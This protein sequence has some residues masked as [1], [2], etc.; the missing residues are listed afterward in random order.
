ML[1]PVLVVLA[2]VAITIFIISPFPVS[3][4]YTSYVAS[5]AS[6]RSGVP[7]EWQSSQLINVQCTG[8]HVVEYKLERLDGVS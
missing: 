6:A 2:R 1:V 3:R 4:S 8:V 5:A 7:A